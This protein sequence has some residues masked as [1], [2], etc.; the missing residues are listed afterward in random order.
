MDDGNMKKIE[1]N[2][3]VEAEFTPTIYFIG[4]FHLITK[5]DIS[6]EMIVFLNDR[7]ACYFN[8]IFWTLYSTFNLLRLLWVK[9]IG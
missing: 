3:K 5:V 8:F 1:E 9:V 4:D 7:W 2:A 6:H